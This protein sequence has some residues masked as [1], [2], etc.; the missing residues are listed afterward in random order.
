MELKER[1]DFEKFLRWG[2]KTAIAKLARVSRMTLDRWLKGE[3]VVSTVEPYFIA[4]AMK[5]KQEI[6]QRM[7]ALVCN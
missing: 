1:K 4:Y 3:V 2:D 7:E 6:E 5:R